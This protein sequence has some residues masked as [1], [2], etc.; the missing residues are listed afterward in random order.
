MEMATQNGIP[1]IQRRPTEEVERAITAIRYHR[2]LP[3]FQQPSGALPEALDT[4]FLAHFMDIVNFTKAY[5]HE[6]QWLEQLPIIYRNAYKPTVNFSLRALSMACYG[7]QYHNPSI[8]VDS[9]RWYT[10]SLSAQRMSISQLTKND[11][12]REE[13]VLIPLI[14]STYEFCL[15]STNRG[16]VSLLTAASETLKMR[17]P[18]NTKTDTMFPL[19]K[20]IRGSEVGYCI[21]VS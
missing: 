14:L 16:A 17:G 5:C 18:S 3:T 1:S 12:P 4:A 20:G 13:E 11:I 10:L 8:L 2:K 6:M 7:K 9:W 21:L 15:G 19:F